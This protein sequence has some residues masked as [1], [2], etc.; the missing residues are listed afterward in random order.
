MSS[1]SSAIARS[2]S[3]SRVRLSHTAATSST[4]ASRRHPPFEVDRPKA[5][6]HESRRRVL[7]F[8]Q[9]RRDCRSWSD[10]SRPG[11]GGAAHGGQSFSRGICRLGDRSRIAPASQVAEADTFDIARQSERRQ[12]L[13]PI[14]LRVNHRRHGNQAAGQPKQVQFLP[15]Y[16]GIVLVDAAGPPVRAGRRGRA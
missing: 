5:Q 1:T 9:R 4:R 3:C 16:R 6:I 11:E 12:I 2:G 14:R 13:Q 10:P 8:Q 7:P 15:A